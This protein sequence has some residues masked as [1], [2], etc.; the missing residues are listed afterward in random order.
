MLS[1]FNHVP[2]WTSSAT[3]PLGVEERKKE[4]RG[5]I[6]NNVVVYVKADVETCKNRDYKGA[7]AKA[8]SGEFKNFPSVNEV[9]EELKKVEVVID[10]DTISVDETGSII[11]EPIKNNSVK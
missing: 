10:T 5:A 3:P 2:L 1:A 4:P 6:N 9:Y 7:Y 8:L 11:V